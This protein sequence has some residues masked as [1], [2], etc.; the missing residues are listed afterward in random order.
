[1]TDTDLRYPVGKWS[2]APAIDADT[3]RKL[4]ADI[5]ALPRQLAAAVEGLDDGRLDTPY[6]PEGWTPRQIVNHVMDSHLNAYIRFKLAVTEDNPTIKPY[7]E[8]TWA[9]TIDGRTTAVSVTL[10][11]IDGLHQRWVQFLRSLEPSAFARTLVHPERGSMT[12]DTLLQLYAWHGRH[13]TAHITELRK[14]QGWT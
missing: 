11:V 1:V 13:H 14:R 5:D 12:L 7:D 2:P 4:I 10:P 3:R 6:R 8:K 9:E